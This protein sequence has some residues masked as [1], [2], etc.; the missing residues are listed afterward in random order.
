ML[1]VNG[2]QI[3][4]SLAIARYLATKAK[5]CGKDDLEAARADTVVLQMNDIYDSE[6]A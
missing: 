2:V 3:Y 1:E 6:L 5:L 4:Q